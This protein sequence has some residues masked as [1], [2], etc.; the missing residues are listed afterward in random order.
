MRLCNT[1]FL[2]Q[3]AAIDEWMIQKIDQQ[4][5]ATIMFHAQAFTYFSMRSVTIKYSVLAL[6]RHLANSSKLV[7]LDL[8]WQDVLRGINFLGKTVFKF[9]VLTP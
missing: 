3:I 9:R 7:S 5:V 8:S 4:P 1:D 2:W 6:L